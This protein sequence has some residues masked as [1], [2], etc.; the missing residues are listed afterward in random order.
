M[1]FREQ[2]SVKISWLDDLNVKSVLVKGEWDSWANAFPL[3]RDQNEWSTILRLSPGNYLCKFIVDGNWQQSKFLPK[4]EDHNFNNII[5]VN[6]NV[7]RRSL[8]DYFN[9]FNEKIASELRRHQD[10]APS[11]L[12][13]NQLFTDWKATKK[14]PKS[15]KFPPLPTLP[16]DCP[17]PRLSDF[18]C[19]PF[20]LNL[21]DELNEMWNTNWNKS[22]KYGDYLAGPNGIGKSILLY[23][24]TCLARAMGFIVVYSP[25]CDIWAAK[26]EELN[27]L[28]HIWLAFLR[29]LLDDLDLV[30]DIDL[31]GSPL[32]RMVCL[33]YKE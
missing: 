33:S 19:H 17:D 1:I 7:V 24:I 26:S 20:L 23:Q 25:D 18:M 3:Y 22:M 14:F 31:S 5:C 32:R 6:R 13:L 9:E 2:Q 27:Q 21:F 11:Y 8:E 29:G 15:L 28:E 30:I 10:N 16:K 12:S 4:S